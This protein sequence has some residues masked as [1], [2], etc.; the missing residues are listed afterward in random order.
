MAIRSFPGGHIR[1]APFQELQEFKGPDINNG[2]LQEI[3]AICQA[4]CWGKPLEDILNVWQ[5]F[6]IAAEQIKTGGKNIKGNLAFI[7]S[8]K[9]TGNS[10]PIAN[11]YRKII[12][13]L[14]KQQVVAA[15]EKLVLKG[16]FGIGD[17]G[18]RMFDEIL[19]LGG[20][21]YLYTQYTRKNLFHGIGKAWGN[22]MGIDQQHITKRLGLQNYNNP[23][24]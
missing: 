15:Y 12:D 19:Y 3:I 8:G 24:Q 22:L 14:F 10:L 7:A 20:K 17:L 18:A 16:L 5:V 6:L 13:T 21:A 2:K 23:P 1:K 4:L 9:K 11:N